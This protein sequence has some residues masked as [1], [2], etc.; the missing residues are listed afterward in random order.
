M[1]TGRWAGAALLLLPGALTV[2][3]SFNAGGFFPNTPAFVALLLAGVLSLRICSPGSLSRAHRAAG[4]GRGR[5][6]LLGGWT[7]LSA[8]WSDAPGHAVVEFDRALALPARARAVRLARGR[9][10]TSA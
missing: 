2:Y 1:V 9:L 8:I 5:A 3:L 10:T 7:L 4:G 6:A